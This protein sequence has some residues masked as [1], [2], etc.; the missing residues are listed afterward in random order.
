M[1]LSLSKRREPADRSRLIAAIEARGRARQQLEEKRETLERLQTVCDRAD[2]AARAAAD[3]TRAANAARQ[4]WVRDGCLQHA[5]THHALAEAAAAAAGVA[6]RAAVDADAIRKGNALRQAQ[7]ALESA[8]VDVQGAE[9]A[10]TA[11]I[12]AIIA[13]EA[14]PLLERFERAA[15]DYRAARAEVMG[16]LAVLER[17][18]SLATKDRMNPAREG[19]AVIAAAIERCK[20]KSWHDEGETPRAR[21]CLNKTSY[22][23]DW[24][25]SLSAPW[26]KRAAELRQ[27]PLC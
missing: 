9:D 8:H 1:L 23:Q 12:A 22:H 2:V 20:I 26:R 6:Q 5:K 24:L 25:D 7:G 14:A 11:A 13:A 4:D 10:I 16:V 18:W 19:E 17:E 15:A 3:A 27:D 21:D